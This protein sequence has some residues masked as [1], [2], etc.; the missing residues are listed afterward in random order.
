MSDSERSEVLS[1]EEVQVVKKSCV[2]ERGRFQELGPQFEQHFSPQELASVWGL[3]ST[4]VRRMF[5]EEPGVLR[6]GEPSRR[7]GRKL[8]RSYYTLRIPAS[9][10]ERVHRRMCRNAGSYAVQ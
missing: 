5:Q 4:K 9:V 1:S 8:K 7:L 3:S 6:I 2:G 10:A